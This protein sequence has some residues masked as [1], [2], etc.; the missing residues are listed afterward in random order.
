MVTACQL[1]F[2]KAVETLR[3][4]SLRNVRRTRGAQPC[5]A[6]SVASAAQL[7]LRGSQSPP[8]D[9]RRVQRPCEP[10]GGWPLVASARALSAAGSRRW[11]EDLDEGG[12]CEEHTKGPR[13]SPLGSPVTHF[14]SGTPPSFLKLSRHHPTSGSLH[15]LFPLSRP[16]FREISAWVSLRLLQDLLQMSPSPT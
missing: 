12:R 8:K 6:L 3:C 14:P 16:F 4:V 5:E 15:L 13:L 1:H 9:G 7:G 2:S 10:Q 11:G